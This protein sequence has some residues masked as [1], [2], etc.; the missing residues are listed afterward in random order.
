LAAKD[1]STRFD[2]EGT[3][4]KIHKFELIEYE[5]DDSRMVSVKFVSDGN[6]TRIVEIFETESSMS[7]E[8]QRAGWQA[9]LNNFKKFAESHNK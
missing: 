7:S 3:Y 1:G 6:M 2:F 8:Q 5:I 4:T 9:I